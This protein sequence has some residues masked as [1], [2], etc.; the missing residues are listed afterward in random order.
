MSTRSGRTVKPVLFAIPPPGP[1]RKVK[2]ARKVLPVFK[3]ESADKMS[4]GGDTTDDNSA[5]G[6]EDV[7]MDE[8]LE[9]EDVFA[10]KKG[11]TKGKTGPI[12]SVS[13]Y[14]FGTI[15]PL[16]TTITLDTTTPRFVLTPFSTHSTQAHSI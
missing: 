10:R 9:S 3:Y 14:I 16:D 2:V 13:N 6:E 4:D 7:E 5:V 1:G 15:P 11:T 8:E 12:S